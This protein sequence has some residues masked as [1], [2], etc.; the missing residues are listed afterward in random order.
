MHAPTRPAATRQAI[1]RWA[2]ASILQRAWAERSA[3]ALPLINGWQGLD[4]ERCVSQSATFNPAAA[5]IRVV[6]SS[7]DLLVLGLQLIRQSGQ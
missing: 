6:A 1:A 3:F 4:C 7:A 5:P 2:L